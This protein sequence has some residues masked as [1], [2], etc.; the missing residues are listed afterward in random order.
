MNKFGRKLVCGILIGSMAA[1]G[2][3]G[4]GKKLD[5]TQTAAMVGEDAVSL[6]LANLALRIQQADTT[7]YYLIM[8]QQYGINMGNAIWDNQED[9]KSVGEG[10]KESIMD[11]LHMQFLVRDYAPD[12][13]VVLTDEEKEKID[14]AAEAFISENAKSVLK[15]TGVTKENVAEFLELITYQHKMYDVLTADV[16]V[17]VSDEEAKQT[18]ISY[19]KVSTAGTAGED[20]TTVELTDEEK[21]AKKELAQKVL[22][23]VK[24]SSNVAEADMDEL[25]KQ[26]DE[27]LSGSS[28]TYGSDDTALE[29]VVKNYAK[30]LHD[31]ALCDKVIEGK[32]A[33][34][35]LRLDKEIDRD[36]TDTK[37][38]NIITERKDEAFTKQVEEW[39]AAETMTTEAVWDTIKVTDSEP[40]SLKADE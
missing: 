10:L 3:T 11:T 35:V 28:T 4:C 2:L 38:E 40:Y 26:V 37:K 39:K 29:D 1:A 32:D 12:Y 23:K 25:A 21:K 8:A 15:K 19:V 17:N 13:K 31:G 34:Y 7:N 22:D 16:D 33:Y 30:G 36:A 14:A 20:G 9:G 27:S 24:G 6:G 18:R 5:G